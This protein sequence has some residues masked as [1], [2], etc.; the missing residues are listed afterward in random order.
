M[1]WFWLN[2]PLMSVFFLATAG[3]PMWL[4]LRHPE[5]GP[6]R[7]RRSTLTRSLRMDATPQSVPVIVVESPAAERVLTR[8]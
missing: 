3:I 7:T 6:A 4:T 5:S 1:S 2:V 8:A